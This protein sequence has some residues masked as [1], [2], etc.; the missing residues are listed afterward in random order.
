[1]ELYI[2]LPFC[3]SK[4]RYCDFA[5][6]AGCESHMSAYVDTL[7]QEASVE[8]KKLTSTAIET[9][10]IGG[11]T[12]SLLPAELLDR[13]LNGIR[14]TFHIAPDAE[15]TS[16]ANPGTLT[17]AWLQTAVKYGVNRLSM[18]MQAYQPELLKILGRIHH[19][20]LVKQSVTA[21]R[22]AGIQNI[23]LDLMFG[24]PGQTIEQW[25]ETI[26]A[27]LSLQ[28]QHLSCYGLIPEEGTPLKADLD[29]GRLHLPDE[30]TERAMYDETLAILANHGFEQYEI[31]NFAKPGYAC[32]HNLGYWRQVPY[33]GLGASASSMLLTDQPENA[34]VRQTNPPKLDD[35]MHMVEHGRWDEREIIPIDHSDACF[36]TMM[37]GLRTTAGVSVDAFRQMHGISI[38]A[39]YGT[40]LADFEQRGL[41]E[42]TDN[43]WRLTRL[44]MDV[45]NAILV[46]LMDD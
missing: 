29:A 4:C 11:G 36:E 37:L 28:P 2:H 14:N 23:S 31:S 34:Y 10:F 24:L 21:A 38:D 30:E 8:A 9:I 16:E 20:D 27:A 26:L 46:E 43:H 19:F 41:L 44:G 40:K 1:M 45:Q 42:Y 33:L 13:L 12:P 18:G 25:Q 3:K 5:S 15:F 39:C 7:L 35:Y 22:A 17:K 32:R 6:Y